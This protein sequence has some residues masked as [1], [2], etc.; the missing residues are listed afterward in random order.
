[1]LLS[2]D[3]GEFGQAISAY[4]RLLDMNKRGADDEVLELIAKEVLRAESDKDSDKEEV[5]KEKD[6]M[7]KL[8][9]RIT[10]NHQTLSSKVGST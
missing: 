2:V 8:L 4:H 1:M 5:K 10:A 6:E 9:A 7:V 3:V